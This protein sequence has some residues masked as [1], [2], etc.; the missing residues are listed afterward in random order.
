MLHLGTKRRSPS[1]RIINTNIPETDIQTTFLVFFFD[2]PEF[3]SFAAVGPL[4]GLVGTRPDDG[5]T[6]T[7]VPVGDAVTGEC[8][9][10]AGAIVELS[11]R[12]NGFP[13]FLHNKN[14]HELLKN[15]SYKCIKHITQISDVTEISKGTENK[16]NFG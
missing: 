7:T 6:E 2:F 8:G 10:C 15:Q 5:V 14:H 3:D 11:L 16:G 1:T 13:S 9:G 4:V 12:L